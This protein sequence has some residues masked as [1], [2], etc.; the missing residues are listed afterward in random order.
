MEPTVLS[1]A[2]NVHILSNLYPFFMP[3]QREGTR[4][5]LLA[6]YCFSTRK[7]GG[8]PQ[9]FSCLLS[10]SN[11]P[12]NEMNCKLIQTAKSFFCYGVK[13]EE[14][15][16]KLT[17][18]TVFKDKYRVKTVEMEKLLKVCWKGKGRH[19]FNFNHQK[20]W[21]WKTRV[22]LQSQGHQLPFAID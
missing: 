14:T 18:K 20:P 5:Q 21:P 10:T 15:T 7:K 8:K 17:C 22:F 13:S 2:A 4:E 12:R 11:H 9:N 19:M 16:K 3:Y 1:K 6:Y